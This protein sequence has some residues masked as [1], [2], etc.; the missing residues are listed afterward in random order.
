MG[1]LTR[2][3]SE[4]LSLLRMDSQRRKRALCRHA[5]LLL[6]L[7]SEL[8]FCISSIGGDSIFRSRARIK[9]DMNMS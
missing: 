9:R 4:V 2:V 3:G 1:N 7:L 5:F 6:A 8:L